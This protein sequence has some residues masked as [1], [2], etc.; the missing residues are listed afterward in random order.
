MEKHYLDAPIDPS[1]QQKLVEL[2]KQVNEYLDGP[3][4]MV[5]NGESFSRRNIMY[6][7]VY[8]GLAHGLDEHKRRLYLTWM[9]DPLASGVFEHEFMTILSRIHVAILMIKRM[10]EEAL[11]NLPGPS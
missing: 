2:R 11:K 7:F 9:S 10:N 8:G 6:T 3:S 4:H 5:F 1:L